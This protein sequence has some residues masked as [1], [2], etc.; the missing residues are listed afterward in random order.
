[1]KKTIAGTLIIMLSVVAVMLFYSFEKND[2]RF[3]R[4]YNIV[5]KWELPEILNE[6]SAIDWIGTNSIA[7]VQ[8]ED[9]TLFIYDLKANKK[10]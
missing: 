1:M 4:N 10:V 7:A 5:E 9:G 3:K 2:A 8:D 6:V